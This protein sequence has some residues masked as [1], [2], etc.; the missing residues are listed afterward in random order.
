MV[1]QWWNKIGDFL[2]SYG[3][4]LQAWPYISSYSTCTLLLCLTQLTHQ[5]KRCTHNVTFAKVILLDKC[6]GALWLDVHILTILPGAYEHRETQ[7][8]TITNFNCISTFAYRTVKTLVVKITLA[9]LVNYSISPSFF[10]NF[11][12]FHNI[13]YANGLQFAK[14]FSTKLSTILI[15]QRFLPPKFLLYGI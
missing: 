9:N 13:S 1:E 7:R 8:S 4:L 2:C 12:I 3:W 10:T 5:P 11:H 14:V 6:E 15:R